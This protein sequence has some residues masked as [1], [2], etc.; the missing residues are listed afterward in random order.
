MNSNQTAAHS[1]VQVSV[2]YPIKMW[3]C[4]WVRLVCRGLLQWLWH[5]RATGCLARANCWG[6]SRCIPVGA[7]VQWEGL[8]RTAGTVSL[9]LPLSL[10]AESVQDAC[11]ML[12]SQA[13]SSSH[14]ISL[15]FDYRI[16]VKAFAAVR[17]VSGALIPFRCRW[18][19]VRGNSISFLYQLVKWLETLR[20]MKTNHFS[21]A[22][23]KCSIFACEFCAHTYI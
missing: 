11:L 2:L 3:G 22:F 9:T 15:D 13:A 10:W 12:V 14:F 8:S 20:D 19:F 6:H 4:K 1:S 21:V 5:F 16:S 18:H 7:S 17:G 23:M